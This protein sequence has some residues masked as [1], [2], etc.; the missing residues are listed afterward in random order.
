MW[1]SPDA[2]NGAYP[3]YVSSQGAGVGPISAAHRAGLLGNPDYRA[4][5]LYMWTV[6]AAE[7]LLWS[8]LLWCSSG[9]GIGTLRSRSYTRPES[10]ARSHAARECSRARDQ[11]R[12]HSLLRLPP[13]VAPG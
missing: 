6:L 9:F 1:E 4:L 5:L 2:L 11:V 3:A 8:W 13:A 7:A 10:G 12:Q